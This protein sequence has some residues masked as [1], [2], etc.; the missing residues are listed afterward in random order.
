MFAYIE[1]Y[2]TNKC[3]YNTLCKKKKKKKKKKK[4]DSS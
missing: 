1:M 2:V 3:M 4:Y